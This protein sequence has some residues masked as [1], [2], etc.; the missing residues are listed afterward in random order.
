MP[1]LVLKS[2]VPDGLGLRRLTFDRGLEGHTAPGQFVTV[3]LEGHKPAYFALASVPGQPVELLVKVQGD[4]AEELADARPGAQV[5]ISEPIGHGFPLDPS[6]TRPLLVLATGSGLSAVRPV[7]EAEVARGLPRE[8]TLLYGVY[9]PDH[10]SYP[11]RLKAWR[12]AGVRAHVVVS[13]DVPDWDGLTGF[14]QQAAQELGFVKPGRVVL[15]C[16]YPAMVNEAKALWLAA[17]ADGADLL[18]NF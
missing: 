12:A 13:D 6:D 10:V 2:N 3:H 7:I 8:V 1:V 9:T 5:E 17:G 11:E 14:V 4:A 16:G 18:T 15:L